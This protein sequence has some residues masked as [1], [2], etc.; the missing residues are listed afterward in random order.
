MDPDHKE[1]MLD[2]DMCLAYASNLELTYCKKATSQCGLCTRIF[3]DGRAGPL[4]D[5]GHKECCAWTNDNFIFK[6]G[7]IEE[8]ES[9][10]MCGHEVSTPDG[11]PKIR[12][13][14]CRAENKR[15][16]IGDCND[17][18]NPKG[19]AF[20]DMMVFATNE[21]VWHTF[22]RQA[23]QI[24]TNNGFTSLTELVPGESNITPIV[25]QY[26]WHRWAGKQ[27]ERRTTDAPE[28]DILREKTKE[29]LATRDE[30]YIAKVE[31]FNKWKEASA[32]KA[33]RQSKWAKGKTP[34][35]IAER[36][37]RKAAEKAA[38]KAQR[39]I[40]KAKRKAAHKAARLAF[41]SRAN[42]ASV[43][44]KK[45]KNKGASLA[46]EEPSDSE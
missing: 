10:N 38:R 18:N 45:N 19:P 15:I 43:V 24:A 4:M 12:S 26:P 31:K 20:D 6:S 34:E 30:D 46:Q 17:I 44:I 3:G 40:E 42:A 7:G 16:S 5:I 11:L 9:I 13:A 32:S 25:N 14:C 33:A 35:Q 37:A 29:A 8:G 2:T 23:W 41:R 22:F 1:M 36:A 21:Q 27:G 28:F 39:A